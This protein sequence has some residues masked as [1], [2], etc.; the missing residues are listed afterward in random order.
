MKFVDTLT[1]TVEGGHGGNGVISF[2]REKYVPKGGPDGGHGG[3]GGDVVLRGDKGTQTLLD[4]R[5]KRAYKAE[6]G[7]NGR[8]R[9]QT[10]HSGAD[11]IIPVPFGTIVYDEE[12][13]EVIV[14]ISEELPEFILAHG[15]RGGRGNSAFAT[16]TQRAP[17]TQED[18]EAGEFRSVRLEL[19]LIAD[20][21]IVGS[22][23][24]GKSTFISVVSAAKP[25]IADYPFT[26]LAPVLGVVKDSY[27]GAFVIADM[28]GL[29]EGAHTGVGLGLQF[30]RHIERTRIL[31]HFIDSSDEVSMIDRY[32]AIRQEL[33]SYE[34]GEG[35]DI[36]DKEEI[37]V[38]TKIDSANQDNL[39][40]FAEYAKGLGKKFFKISSLSKDGVAEL[41]GCIT[42][43]LREESEGY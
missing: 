40:E 8:G 19:K 38:A 12:S 6:N 18:G 32:L 22:P 28:P 24:A 21:G 36:L 9:D 1:M 33:D 3:V 34:A 10:G 39:T 17:R 15:G 20:V 23:N 2:R 5:Y 35:F 27:G 30:L 37:L 14:D 31:L 41:I 16:P 25:K 13:G 26:T 4:L 42:G 43:M 7:E 29:V 11:L